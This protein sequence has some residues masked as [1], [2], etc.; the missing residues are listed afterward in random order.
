MSRLLDGINGPADLKQLDPASMPALAKEIRQELVATVTNSGGHLASNLGVVELTIAIH[1]VFDSPRDK[2]VWDV[3]HQ[4]YVHKLLT[5]RRERFSTL[6]QFG[7]LSGFTDRS[8]SPHDPF[9]G[10]HASTSVSAALGMAIARDLNKDDFSVVAVI[11]DGALTGGM[12]FEA[13]NNAGHADTRLIVILNDNR[14]SI[15]PTVGALSSHLNRLWFDE[16]VESA[17]DKAQRVLSAFATGKRLIWLGKRVKSSFKSFLLPAG[18]WEELGFTYMGPFDGHDIVK[19]EKALVQA[20]D[21]KHRKPVFIHVMTTKGKGYGP[22]E[23]DCVR[24]HGVSGNGSRP[25]APAYSEVFS[26]TLFRIMKE[27][28]K[29]VVI[30]AAMAEGNCLG[31][32][33]REFPSRFFDVGICEEH[34]ATFAAGL[35][36][37]GLV[38]VLAIYSTFM[39]RAYDQTIHD[40]CLQNLP[41]V[42]AMDRSG[43]VGDDGKTHQGIFD[44][45]YLTPIPNLVVASPKDGSEL[46]DLLLTAVRSARP[47]AIR[48]PRGQ[49]PDLERCAAGREL[50]LGKGEV[51]RRGGDVTLLAIGS[52]VLPATE[53]ATTLAQ[54]GVEATVVNARFAKPLDGDLI[55]ECC[56]A[57]PRVVTVEENVLAGGFG[58][59]V[60]QL[61]QRSALDGVKVQS[62]GIPDEFVEHGT[63]GQLRA[64]YRLDAGG[65]VQ[66]VLSGYPELVARQR[67][68]LAASS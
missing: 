16:R 47:M 9:G 2:V 63:Q 20:R 23:E 67:E 4:S 59:A 53:A 56:R 36:A 7:G 45:S 15:S 32:V 55:L 39:Q 65:I 51:L 68:R 29:V 49:T 6:R 46:Q 37:Q 14:M 61:I 11:G 21:Y 5:G 62:I 42:I 50:P 25:A 30:T 19:L 54:L 38:P 10:G 22:A 3:G 58:S 64:R 48:Y 1:R 17:E 31:A 33:A 57:A 41:V 12:A 13:L 44:L 34:A 8:E 28:E 18:I 35:A 27:H 40:I 60:L 66:T 43:I 24:Y 52:T 26:D